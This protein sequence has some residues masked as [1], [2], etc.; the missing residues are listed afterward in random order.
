MYL[1][2]FSDNELIRPF[3][4][5]RSQA[6]EE[7]R[8]QYPFGLPRGSGGYRKNVSVMFNPYKKSYKASLPAQRRSYR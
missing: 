6:Q 1:E 4:M 5:S 2:P 7:L 3:G 8:K